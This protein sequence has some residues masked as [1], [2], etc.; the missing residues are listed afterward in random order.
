MKQLKEILTIASFA[1]SI[2]GINAQELPEVK[3]LSDNQDTV[4]YKYTPLTPEEQLA[5]AP[6]EEADSSSKRP[7]KVWKKINGYF[8]RANQD[9]TFEKKFDVTFIGGPSYSASTSLGIG[10]MAAGLYRTDRTDSLTRPSDV[11]LFGA[12]SIT[13]FYTIGIRGNT[14]FYHDKNRLNYKLQFS[15]KPLDYWGVGYNNGASDRNIEYYENFYRIDLDYLHRLARNFYGGFQ[16]GFH[17][18]K[19]RG[20]GRYT[21]E[22]LIAMTNGQRVQY[23]YAGIGAVLEYDSRDFAPNPYRGLYVS[24][25]VMFYPEFLG[26]CDNNLW[27]A[28]FAASTYQRLWKT[29]LLAAELRGEFNSQETPWPFLARMGGNERMRGYYEGRYTDVN[30]ITLQVE[31]R[32]RIWRRISGVVWGGAGNVFPSFGEFSWSEVLPNYGIGFRWEFKKRVNIRFDYGFG[33]G[34]SALVMQINEAF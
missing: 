34:C 29:G 10:V 13:G 32:Q 30:L 17:Y 31:L 18:V 14:I 23:N 9:R 28:E 15:S 1:L 26:N 11:T 3:F 6:I 27:K 4:S 12:V 20:K 16:A 5:V 19:G 25:S 8:Q 24:G 33:K 7:H 21:R 22:D 2:I